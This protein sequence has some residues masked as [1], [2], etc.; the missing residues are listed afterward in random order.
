MLCSAL[1]VSAEKI[2]GVKGQKKHQDRK[3]APISLPPLYQCQLRGRTGHAP[4]EDLFMEKYPFLEKC[5]FF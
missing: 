4:S 5:L 1:R 3:I 2:S